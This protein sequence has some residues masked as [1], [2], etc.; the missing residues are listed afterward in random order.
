MSRELLFFVVTIS[1]RDYWP[2]LVFVAAPPSPAVN[3]PENE[4]VLCFRH[5]TATHTF[6]QHFRVAFKTAERVGRR[7]NLCFPLRIKGKKSRRYSYSRSW[8]AALRVT[9]KIRI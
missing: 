8:G 2:F 5:L 1:A 6:S 4:S 3:F 7:P 9:Y